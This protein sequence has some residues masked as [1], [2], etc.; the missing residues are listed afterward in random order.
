MNTGKRPKL[1]LGLKK[2]RQ[3]SQSQNTTEKAPNRFGLRK[4]T[5]VQPKIGIFDPTVPQETRSKFTFGL[6]K[7]QAFINPHIIV[8]P[9]RAAPPKKST[10]TMPKTRGKL[11]VN[12][13][14][15][16][17][18]NWVET[19]KRGW[20]HICIN[21]EGQIVHM[22][23]RPRVWNKLLQANEDWPLWVASITGKIGQRFKNGFELVEPAIQVYEKTTTSPNPSSEN[24]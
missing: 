8:N 1:T 22:N 6:K 5:A 23:V 9:P 20:K 14:I 19:S 21:A 16:A 10:I 13:K 4:K 24:D 17:L 7:K 18:P 11:E 15:T 2:K 12:I 3:D